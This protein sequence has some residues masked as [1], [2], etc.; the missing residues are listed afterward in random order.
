MLPS[1]VYL[2][3]NLVVV[4]P[5]WYIWWEC[6][7][8]KY[9]A[10]NCFYTLPENRFGFC[11]LLNHHH[12]LIVPRRACIVTIAN[13]VHPNSVLLIAAQVRLKRNLSMSEKPVRMCIYIYS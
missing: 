4:N 7:L 6:Q 11:V 2:G 8:P 9:V 12:D 3:S 13:H 1:W 10:I 5:N